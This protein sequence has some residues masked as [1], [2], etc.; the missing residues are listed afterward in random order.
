[1]RRLAVM[2]FMFSCLM[3]P[4]A[5]L[6]ATPCVC[7]DVSCLDIETLDHFFDLGIDPT[8]LDIEAIDLFKQY[9]TDPDSIDI[10]TYDRMF[11]SFDAVTLGCAV[12]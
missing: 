5:I 6:F 1:M 4:K 8:C 3:M 9:F 10:E 2:V 7:N 12:G 11:S